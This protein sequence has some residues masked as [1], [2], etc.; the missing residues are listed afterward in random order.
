MRTLLRALGALALGIG[1]I[2]QFIQ[3]TDPTPPL[4]YFTVWSAILGTFTLALGAIR[5][6]EL[7]V[8]VRGAATIGC[9]I[10]GVIFATV[11]APA[12]VTG[13]WFQP[14][15][16]DWSRT[17]T[18]LMHGIGPVLIAADFIATPAQVTRPWRQAALCCAWPLVYIVTASAVQA[19]G[20]QPVPYPFLDPQHSPAA[21]VILASAL[22]TL[23]FLL[24]GRLLL[25]LSSR[26][27]PRER[28][29]AA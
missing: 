15:D 13:T 16:D 8:T 2:A 19:A 23:F 26:A 28:V 6:R 17:A 11:I 12:T 29:S 27:H 10:S 21:L 20:G 4:A 1:V 25:L 7:S 24:I 3:L 14:W 9:V 22:L 18:V 5:H